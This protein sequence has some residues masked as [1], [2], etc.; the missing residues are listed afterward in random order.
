MAMWAFVVLATT[1]WSADS[2]Q[3]SESQ[4]NTFDDSIPSQFR[5]T[6]THLSQLLRIRQ[7]MEILYSPLAHAGHE[8]HD[9]G[10]GI[11]MEAMRVEEH[12]QKQT[13]TYA[14]L[15]LDQQLVHFEKAADEKQTE[16]GESWYPPSTEAEIKASSRTQVD[17]DALE[18]LMDVEA[19][20]DTTES[21]NRIVEFLGNA[22]KAHELLSRAELD[23]IR[24][25]YIDQTAGT[26]ARYGF[27][28]SPYGHNTDHS[29]IGDE[30]AAR[31][32][33]DTQDEL[34]HAEGDAA[35]PTKRNENVLVRN[36]KE[37]AYL[38]KFL[39]RITSDKQQMEQHEDERGPETTT[40]SELSQ[41]TSVQS[42]EENITNGIEQL[43][44]S[45]KSGS[46]LNGS[47]LN[48]AE[49]SDAVAATL[50]ERTEVESARL[51]KLERDLAELP[52]P[53]HSTTAKAHP[54]SV[55]PITSE[56][57]R[58]PL[59]ALQKRLDHSISAQLD[60]ALG[61][62]KTMGAN[63]NTVDPALKATIEHYM[64]SITA[65][66]LHQCASYQMWNQ[67][68]AV[69]QETMASRAG[70]DTLSHTVPGLHLSSEQLVSHFLESKRLGVE[71]TKVPSSLQHLMTRGVELPGLGQLVVTL[72][73]P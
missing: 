31:K 34:M 53:E 41:L 63:G 20:T 29:R 55:P 62:F 3:L 4:S 32:H 60:D 5:R 9:L 49:S 36:L 71:A 25:F 28:N 26:L 21:I 65:N 15:T 46:D 48:A 43:L 19:S 52:S 67:K 23:R 61:R 13:R 2:I 54:A 7:Q 14:L 68:K 11:G 42:D 17:S 27:E 56:S 37:T 24:Q 44:N 57:V 73:K 72:R 10:D 66:T 8:V 35:G 39:D 22:R 51:A 64:S 18:R 30:V 12:E 40:D 70:E 50:K 69:T 58:V 6:A 33:M 38:S 47:D 1:M 45:I 16:L 59:A